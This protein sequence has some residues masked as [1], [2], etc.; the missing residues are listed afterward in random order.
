MEK[1]PE[2]KFVQRPKNENENKIG[3]SVFEKLE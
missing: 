1:S 3:K 2:N